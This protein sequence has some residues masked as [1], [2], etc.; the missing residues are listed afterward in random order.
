MYSVTKEI[1]FC[2]GHRLLNYVGKC[3]HLHGHNAI[4][5]V[6]L[7]S[8]KLDP[9]SMVYDFSDISRVIKTW[10]DET[11]DH[12]MILCE[13][14]PV[15]PD[16]EKRKE[17]FFKVGTNPTAETIAKLIFDYAVSQ[18]FPV[19]SVKLWETETSFATYYRSAEIK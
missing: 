14:D 7:R 11:L 6:E 1:H 10:I 9:R 5:E 19:H 17:R 15:I 3:Q 4:A 13:K 18:G 8:E 2:Y 12:T 16:L